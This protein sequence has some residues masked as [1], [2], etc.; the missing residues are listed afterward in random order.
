MHGWVRVNTSLR[1]HIINNHDRNEIVDTL[2]DAKKFITLGKGTD[3]NVREQRLVERIN[4]A[5][6]LLIG[7]ET[8]D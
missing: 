5:I 1:T 4:T 2:V 8:S 6:D 7:P 3:L